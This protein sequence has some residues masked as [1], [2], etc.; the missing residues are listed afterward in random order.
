MPSPTEVRTIADDHQ[1][2]YIGSASLMSSLGTCPFLFDSEQI[3]RRVA[4][5]RSRFMV[6]GAE[7]LDRG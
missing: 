4:C 7:S 2:V 1:S 6:L 3:I 5:Q